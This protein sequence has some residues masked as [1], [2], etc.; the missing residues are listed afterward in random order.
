VG[1][2]RNFNQAAFWSA[3]TDEG[4]QK[5]SRFVKNYGL[6]CDRTF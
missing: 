1:K 5:Y 4:K 3:D 6:T 2:F